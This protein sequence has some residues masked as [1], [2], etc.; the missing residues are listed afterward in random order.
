MAVQTDAKARLKRAAGIPKLPYFFNGHTVLTKMDATSRLRK[1]NV[2]PIVY[3]N[4]SR[5]AP[6]G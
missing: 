4:A 5:T 6:S 1:R 3:K 2:Q